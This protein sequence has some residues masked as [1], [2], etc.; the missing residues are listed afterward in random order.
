MWLN[1]LVHVV[2]FSNVTFY[3]CGYL[4]TCHL[5]VV[6]YIFIFI[7]TFLKKGKLYIFNYLFLTHVT[8]ISNFF[9]FFL[10]L[11]T[12]YIYVCISHWIWRKGRCIRRDPRRIFFQLVVEIRRGLAR[13]PTPSIDEN[14]HSK[15]THLVEKEQKIPKD[16]NYSG[17]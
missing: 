3:I 2:T 5:Q 13:I 8:K 17:E 10:I 1:A 11:Y 4:A 14:T 9:F 15:N 12:T 16:T 6:K 7:F